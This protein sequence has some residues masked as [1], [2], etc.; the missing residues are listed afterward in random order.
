VLR[1]LREALQEFEVAT[2]RVVPMALDRGGAGI[3]DELALGFRFSRA[4]CMR[5]VLSL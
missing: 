4:V 3:R 1:V 5:R 2:D